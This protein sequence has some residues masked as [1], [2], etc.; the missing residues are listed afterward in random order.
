MT[1]RY[2]EYDADDAAADLLSQ[3]NRGELPRVL[4][5]SLAQP[6]R[7]V[8]FKS[9]RV[10]W[11]CPTTPEDFAP[12]RK[13]SERILREFLRL[14]SARDL[15]VKEFVEQWGP[16]W[17]C[18]KHARPC[19][20]PVYVEGHS[21]HMVDPYSDLP[22]LEKI[23]GRPYCS[24]HI[25]D[26]R[27]WSRRAFEICQL[28]QHARGN[29]P[30][31][32]EAWPTLPTSIGAVARPWSDKPWQTLAM[33]L[34]NWLRFGALRLVVLP[35]PQ[36]L[37]VDLGMPGDVVGFNPLFAVIGLQLVTFATGTSGVAVCTECNK[38]Y[39]SDRKLAAGRANYCRPCGLRVAW[40]RASAKLRLKKKSPQTHSRKGKRS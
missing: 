24:E 32:P 20:H 23:G 10:R 37:Q 15:S 33:H 6:P 18:D 13:P 12:Y 34:D 39:Q 35:G 36:G 30:L 2:D 29:R 19:G 28:V 11:N 31:A 40:R 22:R 4:V 21:G 27:L 17:L 5:A 26:Y 3:M 9:G 16:L 8:E 25:D 1:E 38:V 14:S 7:R